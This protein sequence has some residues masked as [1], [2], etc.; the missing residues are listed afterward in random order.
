MRFWRKRPREVELT[1]EAYSRWLMAGQ[2]Q[3]IVWFLGLPDLEQSAL[4][5]VGREHLVEV[6]Q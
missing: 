2:P 3:P 4:A 1:E 5:D 6:S